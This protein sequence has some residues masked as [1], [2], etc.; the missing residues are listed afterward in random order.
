MDEIKNNNL[1]LKHVEVNQKEGKDQITLDI[2]DM[3]K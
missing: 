1:R 2:S 3:N